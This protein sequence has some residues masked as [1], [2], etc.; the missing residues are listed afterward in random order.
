[1]KLETVF[2]IQSKVT[3]K[4]DVFFYTK[5]YSFYIPFAMVVTKAVHS[6]KKNI[7]L[8]KLRTEMLL[9]PLLMCLFS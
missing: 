1:M 5:V 3:N 9:S 4:C 8:S 2:Q 6:S 7:I